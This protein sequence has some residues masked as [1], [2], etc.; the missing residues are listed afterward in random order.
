MEKYRFGFFIRLKAFRR[1]LYQF[2]WAR[3]LLSMIKIFTFKGRF[4]DIIIDIR[5]SLSYF[6]SI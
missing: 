5:S 3:P 1:G 2:M 6:Y 4:K